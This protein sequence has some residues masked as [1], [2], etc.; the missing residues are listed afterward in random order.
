MSQSEINP[1]IQRLRNLDWGETISEMRAN[2]EAAFTMPDRSDITI[3]SVDA[4]GVPADLIST[5]EASSERI[6]LY[7]HGGGYLFGSRNS[8]R[9]LASD[10]S[11]AAKAH[12]LLIEYRLAPEHPFPAA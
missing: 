1:I 12:V 5:P 3:E 8:Y 7:L 11:T 4:N 6:I 10:L 9:R 2:F